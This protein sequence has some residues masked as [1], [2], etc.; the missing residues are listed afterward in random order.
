MKKFMIVGFAAASLLGQYASAHVTHH[1]MQVQYAANPSAL[2]TNMPGVT[3]SDATIDNPTTIY[4][5]VD[6]G[7]FRDSFSG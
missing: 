2:A 1:V 4:G 7:G 6:A 5:G 3:P